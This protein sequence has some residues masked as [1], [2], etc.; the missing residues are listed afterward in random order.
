MEL[1]IHRELN[2]HCNI[3]QKG[4]DIEHARLQKWINYQR[5]LYRNGKL[6]DG[7]IERLEWIDFQ[8]TTREEQSQQEW[9]AKF[10]QLLEYK[11]QNGHCR[12]PTRHKENP[13]LAVWVKNQR[14]HEFKLSP[15]RRN[16]LEKIGFC[17]DPKKDIW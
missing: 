7:Y 15:N 3:T 1:C 2:G 5:S 13:Q 10:D 6:P 4:N 14:A 9:D 17:W 11:A 12:V 16:R 8:W